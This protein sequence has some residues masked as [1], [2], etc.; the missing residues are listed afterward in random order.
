VEPDRLADTPPDPVSHHS[1]TD[2]ARYRETDVRSI[3]LGF[4][5]GKS[6]KQRPRKLG[7]TVINPSE[8]FG[9]QQTDTFRKTSDGNLPLGADRELLAST[10][11]AAG[12]HGASV[13]CFHPGT[14]AVRLGT[15]AII[16]LKGAFR[17]GSSSI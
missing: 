14:E 16:R 5:H 12:K 13:L 3:G 6:G 1:F 17:H 9:A 2:G 8:I 7:A 15:V 10:G 4:A 11:T